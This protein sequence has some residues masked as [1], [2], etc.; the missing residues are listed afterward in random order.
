[1][2]SVAGRRADLALQARVKRRRRIAIALAGKL[3]LLS[4]KC[5]RMADNTEYVT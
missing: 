4:G 3:A 2:D 5:L 1:V